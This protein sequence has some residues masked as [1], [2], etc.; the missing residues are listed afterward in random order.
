MPLMFF[1]MFN[2]YAA[3]L[4]YYYF[5]S[6][7]ISILQTMIFRWTLNDKRMLEEMERA[8][9]KKKNAPK[10]KSGFM[11]RLEAM[12]KEQQAR[13]REQIKEQAKKQYR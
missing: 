7:L 8:K 6:L 10:K 9:A 13:M 12:Q 3:G 4:S 2:D 1:F 11:A 5:L